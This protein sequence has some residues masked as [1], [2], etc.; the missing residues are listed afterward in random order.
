MWYHKY[1][2]FH[3]TCGHGSYCITYNDRVSALDVKLCSYNI[4][5]D[6]THPFSIT[7]E[8]NVC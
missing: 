5:G 8:R 7:T 4:I 3:L 2:F 1:G 6:P